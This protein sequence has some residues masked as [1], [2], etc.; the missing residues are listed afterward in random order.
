[1]L[2][3]LFTKGAGFQDS[4]PWHIPARSAFQPNQWRAHFCQQ[5]H[6]DGIEEQ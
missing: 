6:S 4:S 2:Y 1:M 5:M 3:L